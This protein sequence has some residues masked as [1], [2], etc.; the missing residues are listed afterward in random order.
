MADQMGMFPL[1]GTIGNI[2]F[3]KANGKFRARAKGGPSAQQ[4]ATDPQFQRSRENA[5]EFASAAHAGK[6]FR[7][8]FLSL[9]NPVADERMVSRLAGRMVRVLQADTKNGRGMRKVMDGDVELLEGFEFNDNGKLSGSLTVPYHSEINRMTGE[10]KITIPAFIPDNQ[11][12]AP[13]GATHFKL[14]SGGAEVDF[15]NKSYVTELHSTLELPWNN[16]STDE[17][18]FNN[19]VPTNS[20]HA[21]FLVLGIEFFQEMNG[22]KYPLKN[23]SFNA[24]AVIKV[25]GSNLIH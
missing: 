9:V 10:L 14:V 23:G 5:S 11:I 2:N 17:Y 25:S 6:L 8:A 3:Y 18:V 7:R 15:A 16:T 13:P 24:L 22:T 12:T 4:I 21:L 20:T 1:Q 19:I